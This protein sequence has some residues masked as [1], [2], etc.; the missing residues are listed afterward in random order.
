MNGKCVCGAPSVAV[1]RRYCLKCHAAANRR[2]RVKH[3]LTRAQRKKDICRS[4]ANVYLQRG[5]LKRLPCR[6]C[7]SLKSQMH[8]RDYSKP[9][10][11][12]WLCRPCHL[13]E[14]RRT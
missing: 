10:E 7:G 8:H 6:V 13:T 12:D 11:V 3:P 5:F 14:H 1:G 9:L 2:Y 4:Y